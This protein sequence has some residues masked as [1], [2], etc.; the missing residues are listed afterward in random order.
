MAGIL[1]QLVPGRVAGYLAKRHTPE[2]CMPAA[3]WEMRFG[4]ELMVVK[5]NGIEL[6]M[7][8]YVFGSQ[9]NGLQVFQCRWEDGMGKEAYVQDETTRFNLLRGIW[10]G[11]GIHGQKVIEFIISGCADSEQAKAALIRELDKL[12]KVEKPATISGTAKPGQKL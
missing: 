9:G 12:I 6:P 2:A 8:H 11:R 5:V 3:G 10:A 4:P 1:L 7:R